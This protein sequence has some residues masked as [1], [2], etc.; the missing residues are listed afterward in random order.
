MPGRRAVVTGLGAVTPLGN[1]GKASWEGLVA[2]R[3]GTGL[4]QSFDTAP[5]RTRVGGVCTAFDAK[6]LDYP[7]VDRLDR[8][9]QLALAAAGE[10]LGDSGLDAS[11]RSKAGVIVGTGI[12]GISTIDEQHRAIHTKGYR[13]VHPLTVPMVMANAAAGHI[14]LRYGMR[15]T[16]LTLATA[17]ASGANAIGEALRQVRHGYATAVLAGGTE[18]PLSYGI[19][20]GWNAMRVMSVR[21]DDPAGA[22]RPFAKDRDGLVLAEGAAMVVVEEYEH[23]RARGATIYAEVAGY[24][25]NNDGYHATRPSVDGQAAVMRAAL[26]DAGLDTGAVDYISAHGTATA[27]NDATETKAVKAVFGARAAKVPISSIKSALGHS[28]G[29]AGAIEAVASCL[30]LR[31]GVLPPTINYHEPDPE[32]DLDYVPNASRQ[33]Q[34]GTVMSNSFGFGGCNAILVLRRL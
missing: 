33:A 17:C 21:N 31:D 19:F 20:S 7:D 28:L 5:F 26:A 2:A 27:A 32:C 15:G 6:A 9:C 30:T 23:A 14:A 10:A 1:N 34:V 18:A 12:G 25:N 22:V 16:S 4:I 24:A 11:A 8:V 13:W 3:S 29:A